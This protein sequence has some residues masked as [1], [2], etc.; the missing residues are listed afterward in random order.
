M[1]SGD[2]YASTGPEI[3]D[4]WYEDGTVHIATS[5]ASRIILSTALRRQKIVSAKALGTDAVTEADFRLE[6]D[7][8]YFRITVIDAEGNTADT[9]AWFLDTLNG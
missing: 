6:G 7:E 4:L 3:L 5:K 1:K 9:N 2:F 8:G